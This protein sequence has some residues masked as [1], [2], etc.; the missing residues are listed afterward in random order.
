VSVEQ[1]T[2]NAVKDAVTAAKP[3]LINGLMSIS[4]DL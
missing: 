4:T 2:K 1:A 3:F